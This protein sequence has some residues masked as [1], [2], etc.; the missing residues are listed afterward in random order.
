MKKITKKDIEKAAKMKVVSPET[1]LYIGCI[2]KVLQDAID[3]LSIDLDMH[4]ISRT[5]YERIYKSVYC[6]LWDMLHRLEEAG[7]ISDEVYEEIDNFF[8]YYWES[9]DL[10]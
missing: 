2:R 5:E 6:S 7:Q 9:I 10:R 8:F 4:E 1:N 3:E